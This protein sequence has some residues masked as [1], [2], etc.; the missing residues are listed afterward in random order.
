VVLAQAQV[1]LEEERQVATVGLGAMVR[2][3]QAEAAEAVTEITP[4]EALAVPAWSSSAG[5]HR[6]Q[7]P[8]FRRA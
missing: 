1:V 3:I 7:L 2:Q 8:R 4:P 6:R 5:T